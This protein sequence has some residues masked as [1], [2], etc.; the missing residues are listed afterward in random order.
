MDEDNVSRKR[1]RNDVNYRKNKIKVARLK[2]ESHVNHV[3]KQIA[4]KTIGEACRY[5]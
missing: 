3:G 2:G 1:K 4:A 5:V